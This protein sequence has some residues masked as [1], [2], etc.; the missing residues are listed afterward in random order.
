MKSNFSYI[1][2]PLFIV[3][4]LLLLVNDHYFKE[5]YHNGITGKLSDVSGI[6]VFA[7][8]WTALLTD[9]KKQI[10]IWT[11]VVFAFWKTEYSQHLIDFWNALNIVEVGRTIDYTDIICT[12]VLLP[13]YKYAPNKLPSVIPIQKLIAYPLIFITS[14]AFIATSR[15]TRV[16]HN[17]NIFVNKSIKVNSSRE[18]FLN[19][20]EKDQ[21]DYIVTDSV[22][23]IQQDTFSKV[24][25]RNCIIN[26]DTIHRATIGILDKG[27]KLKV[28]V[29]SL[30]LDQEWTT[31]KVEIKEYKKWL[32]KYK[33][34]SIE[35]VKGLG[36]E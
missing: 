14:F 20:L 30:Y 35:L 8:F 27:K 4:L 31:Y 34:E 6:I 1:T 10:F 13:L 21:I 22:I 2:N 12:I 19:Q 36:E 26:P 33:V 32:K 7:L 9:F 29:E 18:A 23:A 5:V 17:K 15:S 3:S 25:L 24:I 16:Y 11:A 28:Y